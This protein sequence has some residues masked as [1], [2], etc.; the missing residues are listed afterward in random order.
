MGIDFDGLGLALERGEQKSHVL[1]LGLE[2]GVLVP[3]HL[4]SR[5]RR[6][7]LFWGRGFY[8]IPVHRYNVPQTTS[9]YNTLKRYPF[10]RV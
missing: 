8:F 3:N 9:L 4:V 10:L 5:Q 7:P 1:H 2:C 6:V